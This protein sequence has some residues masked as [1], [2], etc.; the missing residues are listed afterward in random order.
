MAAFPFLPGSGRG[1][2]LPLCLLEVTVHP[3]SMSSNFV[4]RDSQQQLWPDSTLLWLHLL[5]LCRMPPG[6]LHRSMSHCGS[7]CGFRLLP[8]SPSPA[9]TWALCSTPSASIRCCSIST[10][11]EKNESQV[12]L[13]MLTKHC[14]YP[15]LR[16][17]SWAWFPWFVSWSGSSMASSTRKK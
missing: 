7:S 13:V 1:L 15:S 11:S 10:S 14:P 17:Q 3:C 2:Y 6:F 4:L 16:S 8:T 5:A 12:L 9:W